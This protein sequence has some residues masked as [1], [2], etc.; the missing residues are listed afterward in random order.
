MNSFYKAYIFF[1]GFLIFSIYFILEP[2]EG[3]KRIDYNTQ[4]VAILELNRFKF[5][6]FS[7]NQPDILIVGEKAKQ[8]KDREEFWDFSLT[9]FNAKA[10]VEK[11]RA[12]KI[13]YFDVKYGIRREKKYEFYDGFAYSNN[14][15]VKFRSKE[16]LYLSEQKIFQGNGEFEFENLQGIFRGKN[17]FFNGRTEELKAEL[18]RGKIWLGQ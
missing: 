9:N 14:E 4:E 18:P 13:E 3:K 10:N 15:G 1:L 12:N 7:Y 6:V 5:Y 17:L 8:F 11:N 16:G 2:P